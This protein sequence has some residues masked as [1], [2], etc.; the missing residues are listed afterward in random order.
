MND[1]ELTEKLCGIIAQ[2]AE[3]I[4]EQRNI[5]EQNKLVT[6]PPPKENPIKRILKECSG[7]GA[8]FDGWIY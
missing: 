4:N 1:T 5:I 6:S 2:Q 8:I 7:P 3:I